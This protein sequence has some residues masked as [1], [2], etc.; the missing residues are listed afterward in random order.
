MDIEK[1][2]EANQR[3]MRGRKI[4]RKKY[5]R[6]IDLVLSHYSEKKKIF[7]EESRAIMYFLSEWADR[8]VESDFKKIAL[9]LRPMG[10]MD[11]YPIKPILRDDISGVLLIENEYALE[12]YFSF[13]DLRSR[14][15]E[16]IRL[17]KEGFELI[18]PDVMLD[19]KKLDESLKSVEEND[20]IY[21][22][23]LGRWVSN[24]S[25]TISIKMAVEFNDKEILFSL[26]IRDL[27][28]KE[29]RW[30]QIF[31]RFEP[32][33]VGR[34]ELFWK[35]EFVTDSKVICKFK[36]YFEPLEVELDLG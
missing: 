36:K 3:G 10:M 25:K 20:F 24:P 21:S 8:Q 31:R 26:K 14:Q 22:Q 28:N 33:D 29:N 13:T 11:K 23:E 4:M 7:L 15:K 5:L 1:Q 18:P 6:E 17:L 19:R 34:L 30:E 32:F 27:K 16:I 35:L 2:Q 12:T 9:N